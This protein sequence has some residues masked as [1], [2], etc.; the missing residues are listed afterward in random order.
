MLVIVIVSK[1]PRWWWGCWAN[2]RGQRSVAPLAVH[3]Q[4]RCKIG[5]GGCIPGNDD[6]KTK[7]GVK[8]LF[9]TRTLPGCFTLTSC[10]YCIA[11]TTRSPI[12]HSSSSCCCA[13]SFLH[14]GAAVSLCPSRFLVY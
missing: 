9:C 8:K 3:L 4:P 7:K 12:K 2:V 13:S 6:Q 1:T 10:L 14:R 11:L 5:G